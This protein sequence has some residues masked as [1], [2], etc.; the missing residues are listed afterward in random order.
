[1]HKICY[2]N[3]LPNITTYVMKYNSAFRFSNAGN[4]MLLPQN[5]KFIWFYFNYKY[6]KIK[7]VLQYTVQG[8]SDTA[9]WRWFRQNYDQLVETAASWLW[10]TLIS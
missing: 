2:T 4:A 9:V 8:C 10:F 5:H 6:T 1:M 7:L 3:S